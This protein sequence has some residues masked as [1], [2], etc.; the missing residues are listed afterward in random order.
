MLHDLD[1]NKPSGTIK[2]RVKTF[3]YSLEELKKSFEF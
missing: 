3:A 1:A 2:I